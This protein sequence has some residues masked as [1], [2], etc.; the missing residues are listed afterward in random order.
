MEIR[1]FGT[2]NDS[3]VDGPGIRYAVF[4][5]GC[6]HNCKGCHNPDSH[7]PDGGYLSDTDT[8]LENIKSNPLLDG[9]TFTGG[10]P[11]MQAAAL[12]ELASEIKKSLKGL[13]IVVYTG[14]TIEEILSGADENNHWM[15]FMRYIDILVDGPFIEELRSI[16]LDFKGSANQRI[17]D[18]AKT[19]AEGKIVLADI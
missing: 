14:Y 5:Q 10:E 17:I 18:A 7:D 13:D 15:D 3:I 19:L 2:Q 1:L 8:L 6:N 16:E 12:T 4:V 11:F 9:V